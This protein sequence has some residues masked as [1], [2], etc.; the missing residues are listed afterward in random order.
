V[1]TDALSVGS[2]R[3]TGRRPPHRRTDRPG[4]TEPAQDGPSVVVEEH[5]GGLDRPVGDAAPVQP[6]EDARH[7]EA[8]GG[9]VPGLDGAGNLGE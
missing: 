5:V 4:V 1:P 9:G 7:G 3:V 2:G 6:L 8:E